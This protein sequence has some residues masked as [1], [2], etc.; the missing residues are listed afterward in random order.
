MKKTIIW[1]DFISCSDAQAETE[2]YKLLEYDTIYTGNALVVD[3]ARLMRVR[4]QIDSLVIIFS[5]NQEYN[6]NEYGAL[7]DAPEEFWKSPNV[8]SEILRAAMNKRQAKR[9]TKV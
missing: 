6:V 1:N 8:S 5:D 9:L 7:H 3:Y 2:A 4:N